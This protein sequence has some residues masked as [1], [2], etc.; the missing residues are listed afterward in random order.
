MKRAPEG[1]HK[2][3]LRSVPPLRG[4]FHLHISP[5]AH[6]VGSIITPLRGSRS[7]RLQGFSL[8]SSQ[9]Y[10]HQRSCHLAQRGEAFIFRQTVKIPVINLLDNDSNLEHRKH[11]VEDDLREVAS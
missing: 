10:L 9:P 5:T 6:A 4:S 7:E 1:R 8:R 11:I 2:Y 3:F